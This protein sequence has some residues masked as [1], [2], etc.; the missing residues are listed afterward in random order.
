MTDIVVFIFKSAA[1]DI[2]LLHL[3]LK[4]PPWHTNPGLTLESAPI[5]GQPPTPL[6][7][8]CNRV[9]NA[10]FWPFCNNLIITL[11]TADMLIYISMYTRDSCRLETKKHVHVKAWTTPLVAGLGLAFRVTGGIY[12]CR[13]AGVAVTFNPFLM[14]AEAWLS[15]T[16]LMVNQCKV[17]VEG[18]SGANENNG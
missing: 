6:A 14:F 10:S 15:K 2:H 1:N 9:L 5:S 7:F 8:P 17:V 4:S 11:P 13:L 18:W 12:P 16:T 3:L